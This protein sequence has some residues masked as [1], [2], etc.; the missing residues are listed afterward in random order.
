MDNGVEAAKRI[1]LFCDASGACDGGDIADDNLGSAKRVLGILCA[2][3]VA[4]VQ[5]DVMALLRKQLAGH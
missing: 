4:G 5:Y 1:R 3:G 2:R